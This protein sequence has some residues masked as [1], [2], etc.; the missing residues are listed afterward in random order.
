[1]Q[2]DADSLLFLLTQWKGGQPDPGSV[3]CGRKIPDLSAQVDRDSPS[4]T[5][6]GSVK[7]PSLGKVKKYPC[8]CLGSKEQKI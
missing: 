2:M 1:M 4:N 3:L 6:L 5:D 7:I 8:N